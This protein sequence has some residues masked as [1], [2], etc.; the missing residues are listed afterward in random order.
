MVVG[1]VT[2][3]SAADSVWIG[4]LTSLRWLIL[5]A[6][7]SFEQVDAPSVQNLSV[8]FTLY[9]N[10]TR[11]TSLEGRHSAIELRVWCAGSGI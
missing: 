11:A 7:F 1:S 9:G 2:G 10:R 8:K 4:R 3:S 6:V 5:F